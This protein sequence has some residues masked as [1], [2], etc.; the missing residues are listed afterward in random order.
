MAQL[1]F[2]CNIAKEKRP[3]WVRTIISGLHNIWGKELKGDESE[4][5]TIKPGIDRLIYHMKTAGIIRRT[6]RGH[7]DLVY[8]N[9]T[10]V[11]FVKQ[12]ETVIISIY[13]E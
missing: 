12:N 11:L 3:K 6:N 7:T 10:S 4:F 5:N 9:N 8:D 13:I 1:T 2:K